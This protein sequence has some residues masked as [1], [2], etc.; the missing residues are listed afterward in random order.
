M[1]P[2]YKTIN[3]KVALGKLKEIIQ[4]GDTKKPDGYYC[5]STDDHWKALRR[6]LAS[7]FKKVR[8][9]LKNMVQNLTI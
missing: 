4:S 7:K 8:V 2:Q 6:D 3:W 9:G 5:S 1:S